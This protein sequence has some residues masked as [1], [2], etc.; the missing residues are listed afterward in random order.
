M[1]FSSSCNMMFATA[2]Y[3]FV[4]LFV[5]CYLCFGK[6]LTLLPWIAGIC[7]KEELFYNHT[8]WS[9]SSTLQLR[10]TKKPFLK[11]AHLPNSSANLRCT[12]F[13]Y[14]KT[15][16]FRTCILQ[17]YCTS[18]EPIKFFLGFFSS[19]S[20]TTSF[21]FSSSSSPAANSELR[22]IAAIYIGTI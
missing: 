10:R 22:K 13:H 6:S 19:S 9:M 15:A 16:I 8:T 14:N 4:C 11:N 21:S 2:V 18:S 17:S 5:C 1:K 20:S 7:L 3:L 12:F